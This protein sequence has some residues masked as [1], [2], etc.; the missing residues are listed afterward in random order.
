MLGSGAAPAEGGGA[1]RFRCGWLLKGLEVGCRLAAGAKRGVAA[2]EAPE[3]GGLG[4]RP[5]AIC[6][7]GIMGFPEIGIMGLPCGEG[8]EGF[9]KVKLA[10]LIHAGKRPFNPWMYGFVLHGNST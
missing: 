5:C 4:G 2:A 9:F 10:L 7:P 3:A 6:C 1:A 8:P